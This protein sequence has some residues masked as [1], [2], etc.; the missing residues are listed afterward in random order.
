MSRISPQSSCFLAAILCGLL[1]GCDATVEK[2]PSNEVH[3]LVV[4]ASRSTPSEQAA[5][6]VAIVT[7]RLF[8]TPNVPR[9]PEQLQGLVNADEVTRASG[10][11]YQDRKNRHFGL[12]NEH[13][14]NCHGI[15]GGGDGPASQLQNPY[16]RDFRAGVFKWKS[17]RRPAKPTRDDLL[18]TIR[19]GIPGTGMPSF[20]QLSEEDAQAL[21][22]YVIYLST[23][24]EFERLLL[25]AAIDDLGY[26]EERPDDL[27]RLDGESPGADALAIT[28]QLLEEIGESWSSSDDEVIV[29][30]AETPNDEASVARG[31]ELFHGQIANC[32]GCHGRGGDAQSVATL[33]YD[34]WTK[35]FTTRIAITPTDR[36]AVKPF[37]EAGAPR[38]RQIH[39]RTLTSGVFRGGGDSETL[40]R[41][42]AAGIA[43]TPM[44]A[45][46]IHGQASATGLTADQVWDLV[47]YVQSLGAGGHD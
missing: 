38:P 19:H 46:M 24:G 20:A 15:A 17:T 31:E 4:S 32:V 33:D 18:A 41:R 9:W 26:D 14:V 29:V 35:E 44:P 6:D 30:G 7:E 23:R 10:R 8:G 5:A 34:D 25:D 11:V 28:M 37:R 42:L 47:H 39:P 16:P 1:V 45:V 43:G 27:A 12:F 22:D 13:C 36:D 2:F 40:Y 3:A 21:V